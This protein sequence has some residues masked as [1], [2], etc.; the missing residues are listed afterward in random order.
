[1][2]GTQSRSARGSTA[3]LLLA[4]GLTALALSLAG[5]EQGLGG[6]AYSRTVVSIL[7]DADADQTVS[8][9]GGAAVQV[10]GYGTLKGRVVLDG[11]VSAPAPISPTKDAV[12]IAKAPIVNDRITVDGNQ[13]LANVFIYLPKAPAGT[14][15]PDSLD[16]IKFDQLGCRFLP[17]CL[18]THT[19][20]TILILNSDNTLHNTHTY[21]ERQPGFN[22]GVQ[23]NEKNGVP[24]V[25]SRSEKTPVSVTCDIHPWMQAYQL[26]LDHPYHVVTGEDG[27]FEIS[28]LPAGKHQFTI[29]H[30]VPGVVDNRYEVDIP[31]DG[32]TEVEI[33]VAAQSLA[34]FQGPRPKRVVLSMIP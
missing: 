11:S 5:C 26:P 17:H 15:Q 9:T 29:W 13:G 8:A 27:S 10:A 34:E 20:Q 7:P 23:P 3:N 21:P 6:G 30:E 22:Q 32:T 16:P 24:L 14:K 2:P 18:T 12:C 33:T 4:A 1:M 31:V 19:D 28:N 25:Y